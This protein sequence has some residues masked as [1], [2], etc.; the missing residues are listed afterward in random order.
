MLL[1]KIISPPSCF[2]LISLAEL[3]FSGL[4][5]ICLTTT[6]SLGSQTELDSFKPV[7]VWLLTSTGITELPPPKPWRASSRKGEAAPF[8]WD[9]PHEVSG[10]GFAHFELNY[11]LYPLPRFVAAT[12]TLFVNCKVP[13]EPGA[14]PRPTASSVQSRL[15]CILSLQGSPYITTFCLQIT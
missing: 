14:Q 4:E 10:R 7:A 5:E 13:R 9:R 2:N 15:G 8:G 6:I 1:M 11:E 3:C 12:Q